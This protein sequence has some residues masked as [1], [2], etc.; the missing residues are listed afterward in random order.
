MWSLDYS[1][2]CRGHFIDEGQ[3]AAVLFDL[4]FREA[5]LVAGRTGTTTHGGVGLDEA[6]LQASGFL[7]AAGRTKARQL[8]QLAAQ[9]VG[10]RAHTADRALGGRQKT[11]FC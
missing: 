1:S 11:R 3:R 2:Y 5:A 8:T 6:L 4:R 7:P 10:Q 9:H